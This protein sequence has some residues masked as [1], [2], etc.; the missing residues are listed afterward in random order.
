MGM[1]DDELRS[2]LDHPP[3]VDGELPDSLQLTS[4]IES[5]GQGIVY[6]G[7]YCGEPAAV[8]VYF[9]GQVQTRIEREVLALEQI[10]CH[11]IVKL[12][13]WG[14]LS[15]E[16]YELQVV[17]TELIDGLALDKR[18]N[19]GSL[20]TVEL[21]SVA[22]D[23]ALAIDAMWGYRIVHR[24]LKPSNILI[25]SDGQ[26]CVI[27]LGLARHIELSSLTAMGATWGTYGYLSP[28]QTRGTRQLTC[29]SDVYALGVVLLEAALGR[30]PTRGDQLQLLAH[31][32]AQNLPQE[33]EMWQH[34]ELL[35][36]MLSTRPTIRPKPQQIASQISS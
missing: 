6:S 7:L 34:S 36:R 30:H 9:P 20:D 1:T 4:I 12:L 24:D 10:E 32:F 27:D 3:A 8:K 16:N 29:K 35:K 2:W 5:G 31:N 15:H 17:V 28:E 11:S 19:Q 21:Q 18:L 23:V 13:W 14:T 22:Y 26:A 33:V 25:K